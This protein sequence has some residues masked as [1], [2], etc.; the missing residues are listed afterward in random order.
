MFHLPFSRLAQER[1]QLRTQGPSET[2][3]RSEN[4]ANRE[5]IN[6]T[7]TNEIETKTSQQQNQFRPQSLHF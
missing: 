3:K 6:N 7:N 4:E 5:S 1:T 2:E